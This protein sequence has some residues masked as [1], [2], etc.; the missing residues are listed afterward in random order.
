MD[1][2]PSPK[3]QSHWLA[4]VEIS[5]KEVGV[6]RHELEEINPATGKGDTTTGSVVVIWQLLSDVVVN[7]TMNV[8]D[9]V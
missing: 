9:A 3:A 4:P 5:V 1:V 2:F 8:P 6:L 7:T